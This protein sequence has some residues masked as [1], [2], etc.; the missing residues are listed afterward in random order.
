MKPSWQSQRLFAF[1]N[2][3]C[4]IGPLL[5]LNEANTLHLLKPVGK[6]LIPPSV[7]L[8]L[9]HNTPHWKLPNWMN[10]KELNPGANRQAINWGRSGIGDSGCSID[11]L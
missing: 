10:I 11:Q 8:E 3:V 7:V 4:D 2:L 6:L 9:K 5:H 1:R